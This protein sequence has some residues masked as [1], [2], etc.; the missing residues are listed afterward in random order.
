M[1]VTGQRGELRVGYQVAARLGRW[2]IVPIASQ[3]AAFQ[4]TAT[5]ESE[6]DYWFAK[7]PQDLVLAVGATEWLWRDVRYD[8]RGGEVLLVLTERPVVETRTTIQGRNV[9]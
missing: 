4:F 6:H 9:T 8:Q 3:G 5:V 1:R 7:R 2:E